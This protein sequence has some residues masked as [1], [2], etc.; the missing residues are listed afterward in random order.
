[1]ESSSCSTGGTHCFARARN[2]MICHK[3]KKVNGSE[4]IPNGAYPRNVL[5]D[6]T[7][8]CIIKNYIQTP[9]VIYY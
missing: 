1:M 8:C 4:T 3:R 9:H 6:L 5:N 7:V 2:P